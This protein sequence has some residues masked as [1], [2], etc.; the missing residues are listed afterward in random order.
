METEKDRWKM[1]RRI[2]KNKKK[3]NRKVRGQGGK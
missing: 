3:E 1:N 2:L